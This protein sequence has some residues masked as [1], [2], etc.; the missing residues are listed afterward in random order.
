MHRAPRLPGLLGASYWRLCPGSQTEQQVAPLIWTLGCPTCTRW[1]QCLPS[2]CGRHK[3]LTT[4]HRIYVTCVVVMHK[5]AGVTPPPPTPPRSWRPTLGELLHQAVPCD[6]SMSSSKQR[7]KL[8]KALPSAIHQSRVASPP[9][10]G[11]KQHL[12]S[13]SPPLFVIAYDR[14]PDKACN[15]NL[16]CE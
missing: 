9:A 15:E 6:E 5:G 13:F 1:H 3:P 2:E 4:S 14:D 16:R 10:G 8:R 12:G 7:V 11:H